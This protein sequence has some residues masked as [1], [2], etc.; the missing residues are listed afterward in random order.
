MH[1][2]SAPTCA[3]LKQF[4]H[5]IFIFTLKNIILLNNIFSFQFLPSQAIVI[6]DLGTFQR[7]RVLLNEE[8]KYKSGKV[9]GWVRAHREL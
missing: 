6:I 2:W 9:T 7:A 4:C 8:D 1:N 5:Y 3:A